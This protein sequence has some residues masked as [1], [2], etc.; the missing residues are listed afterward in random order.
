MEEQ[1]LSIGA[2]EGHGDH[3]HPDTGKM[4]FITVD[5][6]RKEVKRGSYIV[7]ELKAA[8][9]VDASKELD[10]VVGGEFRQLEDNQRITIKGGEI[11][12]SHARQGGSS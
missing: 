11:F 2:D 1:K 6:I 10:E 8:V 4:V 12:I 5:T 3:E 9:G 7:S